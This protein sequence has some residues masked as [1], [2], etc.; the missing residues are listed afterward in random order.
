LLVDT[1][2]VLDIM[3]LSLI[4][5]VDD[6]EPLTGVELADRIILLLAEAELTRLEDTEPDDADTR[7]LVAD[8]DIDEPRLADGVTDN[9][10]TRLLVADTLLDIDELPN[11]AVDDGDTEPR[12]AD[13]EGDV[14]IIPARERVAVD[15]LP[16][17]PEAEELDGRI[18]G[19]I[20]PV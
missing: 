3:G 14:P 16:G 8:A 19:D 9:S 17:N 1:P 13:G 12:P 7:L 2:D 18:L 6:I 11:T 10:A 15:E 4:V 20:I 5:S